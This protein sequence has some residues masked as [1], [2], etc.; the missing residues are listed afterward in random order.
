MTVVGDAIA[1]GV[2]EAMRRHKL[3]GEPIVV[4][5]NGKVV[6][7]PAEEIIVPDEA[8]GTKRKPRIPGNG[9]KRRR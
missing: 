7:V 8:N 4:W 6:W 2:R 5:R 1:K 9:R 3:L